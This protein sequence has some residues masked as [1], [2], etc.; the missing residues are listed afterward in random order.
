MPSPL[1]KES[2]PLTGAQK[3]A[4]E[5]M[6]RLIELAQKEW[7][8]N[9]KRSRRYIQLIQGLSTRFRT[10]IPREIKDSFCKKCGNLWKKGETVT[11]RI[12]GK[13]LNMNCKLCGKLT[14]RKMGEKNEKK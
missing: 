14:R 3:I 9:P 12:K 11:I 2:R 13:T 1:K 6:W 8:N 5:R 10:H 7:N 4:V